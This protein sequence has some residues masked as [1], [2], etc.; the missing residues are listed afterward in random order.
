VSQR[1][2]VAE[3]QRTWEVSPHW[4]HSTYDV[5]E[6]LL[7]LEALSVFLFES[8]LSVLV[9]NV[10]KLKQTFCSRKLAPFGSYFC[11]APGLF[12]TLLNSTLLYYLV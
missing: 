1:R 2:E 12:D 4:V 6:F 9:N 11:T 8:R 3:Q 5:V 10:G 7:V